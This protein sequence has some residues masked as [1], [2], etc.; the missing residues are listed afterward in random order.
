M[1]VFLIGNGKKTKDI[2]FLTVFLIYKRSLLKDWV[3]PIVLLSC[4]VTKVLL[5]KKIWVEFNLFLIDL[6]FEFER[7]VLFFFFFNYN[8]NHVEGL[9]DLILLL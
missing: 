7:F 2:V 4:K 9:R 8:Q 6:M 5:N 3:L 1:S